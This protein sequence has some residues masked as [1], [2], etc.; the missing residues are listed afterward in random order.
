MRNDLKMEI[1]TNIIAYK[2]SDIDKLTR[3]MF[4]VLAHYSNWNKREYKKYLLHIYNA[5][6]IENKNITFDDFI[7]FMTSE[8]QK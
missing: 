5:G 6:D 2:W 8:I 1:E 3:A 7:E 4:T